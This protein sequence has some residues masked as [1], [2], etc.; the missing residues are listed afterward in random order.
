MVVVANR[1][2][3]SRQTLYRF[4]RGDPAVAVGIYATVL[5]VLGLIEKLA[6]LAA[7]DSDIVGLALDEERLPKRVRQT[8][9]PGSPSQAD[10]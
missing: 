5:F 1:A 7:A 2:G 4:E 3:I 8:A 6:I 10:A 9:R